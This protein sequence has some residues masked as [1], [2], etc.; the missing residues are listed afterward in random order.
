MPD[1]QTQSPETD[2]TL[3]DPVKVPPPAC[4]VP[5]TRLGIAQGMLPQDDPV[6]LMWDDDGK[7]MMVSPNDTNRNLIPR[8]KI[9]NPHAKPF[10]PSQQATRP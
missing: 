2:P 8:G 10:L 3:A 7:L 4:S 9:L 1:T 6:R 5:P